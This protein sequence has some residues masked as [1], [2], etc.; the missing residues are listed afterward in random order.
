ML[1]KLW[2]TLFPETPLKDRL[3]DQWKMLGFQGTDPATDFRGM[4][5]LGLINLLYFAEN[6]TQVFRKLLQLQQ[7]RQQTGMARDYPVAVTGINL[8]Q[9]LYDLFGV[10]KPIPLDSQQPP[11]KVYKVLFDSPTTFE[12]LYCIAFQL[13]DRTWDEMNA[14]YMDFPKVLSTVRNQIGSNTYQ[15]I[16]P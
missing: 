9:M 10:G 11:G 4:G 14:N 8:T 12:E 2:T 5:L 6:H 15:N 1:I 3:T 13:L 7:Q 16:S